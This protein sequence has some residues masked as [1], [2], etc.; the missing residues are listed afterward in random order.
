[1]AS[2]EVRE[3]MTRC[4]QEHADIV[5]EG[6]KAAVMSLGKDGGADLDWKLKTDLLVT[7]EIARKDF[8][9]PKVGSKRASTVQGDFA[10][11]IP[12]VEIGPIHLAITLPDAGMVDV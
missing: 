4:T 1:M 3:A 11:L 12:P 5:E 7:G 9:V 2:D 6:Y 10:D 8:F